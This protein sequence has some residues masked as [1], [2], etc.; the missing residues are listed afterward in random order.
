MSSPAQLLDGESAP[1][2]MSWIQRRITLTLTITL[3]AR[4]RDWRLGPSIEKII[5]GS[6]CV[7][8]TIAR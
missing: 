1:I 7:S 6:I 5:C 4:K 2:A 3:H 8:Y